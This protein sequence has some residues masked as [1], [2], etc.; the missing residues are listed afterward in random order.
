MWRLFHVSDSVLWGQSLETWGE[1]S[2]E[3]LA[4][5]NRLRVVPVIKQPPCCCWSQ[6]INSP[7][8]RKHNDKNFP[9]SAVT[10]SLLTYWCSLIRWKPSIWAASVGFFNRGASAVFAS[11]WNY[12]DEIHF[13]SCELPVTI[14]FVPKSQIK[15]YLE[16]SQYHCLWPVKT[17]DLSVDASVKQKKIAP[18]HIIEKLECIANIVNF[19]A[20]LWEAY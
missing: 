18:K 7:M 8:A 9:L 12:L 17:E 5:C 4:T 14:M 19:K 3:E 10:S 11:A 16:P 2:Q 1:A 6:H 20:S 13:V 15:L